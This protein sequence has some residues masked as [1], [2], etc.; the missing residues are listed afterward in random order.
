MVVAMR[1][2]I[3]A[4]IWVSCSLA[5]QVQA[6]TQTQTQ[7]LRDP[8]VPVLTGAQPNSAALDAPSDNGLR[9]VF[10]AQGA[11]FALMDGQVLKVGQMT[12]LGRI[13]RITPDAVYVRSES[14]KVER[15]SVYPAVSM[16]PVGS[17]V[18]APRDSG[19]GGKK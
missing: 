14:G 3:A 6:Q 8:T 7:A 5:A 17:L 16:Q 2:L 15:V 9:G 1:V 18:G 12:S 10:Q 19:K 11:P 4:A 13:T